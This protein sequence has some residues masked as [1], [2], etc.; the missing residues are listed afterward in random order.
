MSP[1][2]RDG[3]ATE[4][5]PNSNFLCLKFDCVHRK[6]AGHPGYRGLDFYNRDLGK[7][8]EHLSI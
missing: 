8:D 6:K 4:N 5:S 1:V 3:P 2:D 7:R